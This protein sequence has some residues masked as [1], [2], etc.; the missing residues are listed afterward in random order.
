MTNNLDKS[1]RPQ[2]RSVYKKPAPKSATK[3]AV[4]PPVKPAVKHAEKSAT[5][6]AGKTVA[7][8][9]AKAPVKSGTK[10]A[11][12]PAVKAP[13]KQA[14]KPVIKSSVK[15]SVK[16][17]PNK[18]IHS[19]KMTKQEKK[20]APKKV[21]AK[22]V[23]AKS[24]SDKKPKVKS[25]PTEYQIYFRNKLIKTIVTILFVLAFL[26]TLS[27]YLFFSDEL[28]F[29][30]NSA[31]INIDSKYVTDSDVNNIIEKFDRMQLILVPVNQIETELNDNMTVN[32]ATVKMVFPNSIKIDIITKVPVI[33]GE[34]NGEY[35]YFDD[36]GE[37]IYKSREKPIGIVKIDFS[38]EYLSQKNLIIDAI[39]ISKLIEQDE[40]INAKIT[41]I[42]VYSKSLIYTNLDNNL[43]VVWG[44][45]IN[46]SLKLDV[47]NSI[48]QDPTK[49][50]G[51]EVID[52]TNPLVPIFNPKTE[53]SQILYDTKTT[54]EADVL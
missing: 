43:T 21:P 31:E 1:N 17:E 52:L 2:K 23:S 15:S 12:K 29:D 6:P 4:K 50:V 22:S 11:T 44:D 13:T 34:L 18:P 28:K 33:Y 9:T 38:K 19:H 16:S 26:A 24:V 7:K 10:P 27:Y 45:K 46:M 41:S 25:K 5:K 49:L 48:F 20:L 51:V 37:L 8:H 3:T 53:G 47:L 54:D 14:A 42:S 36:Q 39:N 32:S 40:F 30:K 35:E